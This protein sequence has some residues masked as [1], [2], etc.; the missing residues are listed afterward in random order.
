MLNPLINNKNKWKSAE[1]SAFYFINN[2]IN[3]TLTIEL[4][5]GNLYLIKR[6]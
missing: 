5:L 4:Q 6:K 1:K 3:I 2:R